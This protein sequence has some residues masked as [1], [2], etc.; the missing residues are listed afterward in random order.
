MGCVFAI[1][2]IELSNAGIL[3]LA[4]FS[5]RRHSQ[6]Q[7]LNCLGKISLKKKKNALLAF[8]HLMVQCI[9]AKCR[10][11]GMVIFIIISRLKLLLL[12]YSSHMATRGELRYSP[13]LGSYWTLQKTAPPAQLCP[14]NCGLTLSHRY[15]HTNGKRCLWD[16]QLNMVTW[17]Y[18]INDI[19]LI[20]PCGH[21]RSMMSRPTL[22]MYVHA[23]A[24]QGM[25]CPKLVGQQWV[26]V[27]ASFRFQS[28]PKFRLNPSK[29]DLLKE[30]YDRSA[31]VIPAT[32]FWN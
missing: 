24:Q 11:Q 29:F 22:I 15:M 17:P 4:N 12:K 25:A 7:I 30:M 5:R 16:H 27:T 10:S 19:D 18:Q 1:E 8:Y 6:F 28:K 26:E 3:P 31:L 13:N 20:W 23:A 21:T 2:Q 9:G 32:D 14:M